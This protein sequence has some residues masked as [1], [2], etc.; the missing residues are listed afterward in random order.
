MV[1]ENLD[2]L[3]SI[4][5]GLTAQQGQLLKVNL[6]GQGVPAFLTNENTSGLISTSDTDLYVRAKDWRAAEQMLGTIEQSPRR[7]PQPR[8]E[9]EVIEQACAHCGSHRVEPHVGAVPTWFPLLRKTARPGDDWFHCLECGSHYREGG[10]RFAGL[11]VALGWSA[12]MGALA[13]AI[14]LLINWLRYL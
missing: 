1:S 11:S 7:W 9:P 6:E 13:F 2:K 10:R 8:P 5:S 3:V 12:F 14:I 4:R